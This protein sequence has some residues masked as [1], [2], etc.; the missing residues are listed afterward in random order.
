MK[1]IILVTILFFGLI[2]STHAQDFENAIIEVC[3]D[4]DSVEIFD[5]QILIVSAN[6]T[7]RPEIKE[8]YFL[9]SLKI[10]SFVTMI[11]LYK[12]YK[13]V[14]HRVEDIFL[15]GRNYIKVNISSMAPDSC[16]QTT[17][18]FADMRST[19]VLECDVYHTVIFEHFSVYDY[20]EFYNSWVKKKSNY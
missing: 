1:I 10:E 4:N 2:T 5:Y 8:N 9:P 6:D 7:L 13:I 11:V 16:V 18:I 12:E 17:E 20:Q 3:I 15:S 19:I 14:V